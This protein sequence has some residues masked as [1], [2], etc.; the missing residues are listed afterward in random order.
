MAKGQGLEA[1]VQRGCV[2]AQSSLWWWPVRIFAPG[3]PT[4]PAAYAKGCFRLKPPAHLA[5]ISQR[6]KCVLAG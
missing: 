3:I 5:C 6:W 2:N 4:V 1:D